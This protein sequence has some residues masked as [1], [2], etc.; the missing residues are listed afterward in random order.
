MRERVALVNGSLTVESALGGG[1][2]L[3]VTVPLGV[4]PPE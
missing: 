3:R 2:T 1:T 4:A